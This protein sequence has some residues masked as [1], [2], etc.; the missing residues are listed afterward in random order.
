MERAH[1]RDLTRTIAIEAMLLGFAVFTGSCWRLCPSGESPD[2]LLYFSGSSSPRR[3]FTSGSAAPPV[4]RLAGTTK[5]TRHSAPRHVC[6]PEQSL[7]LLRRVG[8]WSSSATRHRLM[9]LACTLGLLGLIASELGHLG[10]TISVI[11][12]VADIAIVV[13]LIASVRARTPGAERRWLPILAPWTL[14]WTTMI[15][16]QPFL[17]G[18]PSTT[19]KS[20]GSSPAA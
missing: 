4:A 3:S 9:L 5:V 8:P 15:L 12:T 19:W 1:S 2:A 20:D 14:I 17:Y 18:V 10:V 6:R 16:D 13:F 7:G 11:G